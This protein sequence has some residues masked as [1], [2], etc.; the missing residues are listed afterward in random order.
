ML[1]GLGLITLL[2]QAGYAPSS[3]RPITPAAP[4]GVPAA[5]FAVRIT[6]PLGRSGTPGSVRIVAQIQPGQ[7]GDLGPV[8]FFIDG[9]L[10][11]T[12]TDGAPYVAEWV[13]ENPF[14]RREISVSVA[15]ALGHEVRDRVVLEPFDVVE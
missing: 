4:A 2:M 10:F 7:G 11:R 6:S 8:R 3:A 15:D 5:G 14:E 9:Q 12:D 13:D 1:T